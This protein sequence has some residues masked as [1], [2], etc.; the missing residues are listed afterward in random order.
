MN[1]NE[2]A[3]QY[4]ARI[5]AF[6]EGKDPRAVL[7]STPERLRALVASTPPDV[8]QRKPAPDKWSAGAVLAHLADAEIVAGWRVRLI[9]GQDGAPL[10]PFDQEV[11]ANAFR[12]EQVDLHE[13]LATFR[14]A[15]A[16]LLSLLSRV[17]TD[18][19]THHGIHAERGVETIDHLMRLY[20]GHDL[21]HLAQIERLVAPVA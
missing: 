16:S 4:I 21:N 9:L 8:W 13:S 7:A 19:Q 1:R 18:R 10:Q 12:Y 2:T 20:A 3:Q 11:W 17:E 6:S 14:A 5:F 15:R